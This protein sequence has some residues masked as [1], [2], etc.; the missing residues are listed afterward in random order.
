VLLKELKKYNPELLVKQKLLAVTKS[1]MLDEELIEAIK[2]ELPSDIET[3]FIS[4][5]SGMGITELKDLIWIEINKESNKIV[6][7]NHRSMEIMHL[8]D[9]VDDDD[10]EVDDDGG[11]YDDFYDDDDDDD[12][13]QFKGIGWDEL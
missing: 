9:D 4:S 3:I 2:K 5:V 7:I 1:D 6:E 11:F 10:D 12:L 8:D 13:S